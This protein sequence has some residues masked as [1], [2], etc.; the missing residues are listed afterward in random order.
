[1]KPEGSDTLNI[2]Q[3]KRVLMIDDNGLFLLLYRTLLEMNNY[4]VFT[5]LTCDAA[6]ATL[7]TIDAPDLILLDFRLE[8]MSGAEFL[9][10]LEEKRP[11]IIQKV[12]IVFFTAM[13]EVPKSKAVG[14]IRRPIDNDEFVER[15]RRYLEDAA[16]AKPR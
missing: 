16:E 12:P 14:L 4:E 10:Q 1:M 3:K 9:I 13:D 8:G 15:V 6:F 5:A 11:D 7:S 2:S